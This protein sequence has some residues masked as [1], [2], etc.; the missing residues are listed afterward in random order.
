MTISLDESFFQDFSLDLEGNQMQRYP[1]RQLQ[2]E[3]GDRPDVNASTDKCYFG[4]GNTGE[5]RFTC[6]VNN[7]VNAE[8]TDTANNPN[9]TAVYTDLYFK[10]NCLFDS[11]IRFDYRRSQGCQCSAQVVPANG[12]AKSCSCDVCPLNFGPSGFSIDCNFTA[13]NTPQTA[14]DTFVVNTCTSLDCDFGCNGTC[15]LD[16]EN[17]G[18]TCTLCSN[19]PNAPTSAPTGTGGATP[20][21][22]DANKENGGTAA[23]TSG[24][25]VVHA[26]WWSSLF[27]TIVGLVV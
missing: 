23:S 16:C 9:G 5:A 10:V 4:G 12:T 19:N 20:F 11:Q 3:T 7:R 26:Q 27:M 13:D 17:A 22:L 14:N 18:E 25:F 6:E 2:I 24:V 8:F 1:F 21:G 15:R